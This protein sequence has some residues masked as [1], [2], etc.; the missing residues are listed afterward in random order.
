MDQPHKQVVTTYPVAIKARQGR[1]HVLN[2]IPWHPDA[3]TLNCPKC[4][5]MYILT[6][7]FPTDKLLKTLEENHA[8]KQDHPDYVPSDETWTRVADCNC[9]W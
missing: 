4:D 5:T 2:S 8:S 6:L 9:G 1:I 3:G 7:G